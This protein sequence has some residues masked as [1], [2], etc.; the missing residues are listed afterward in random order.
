MRLLEA[1]FD[2]LFIDVLFFIFICDF[3]FFSS[4]RLFRMQLELMRKNEIRY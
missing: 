4:F 3:Q 2:Y 1:G